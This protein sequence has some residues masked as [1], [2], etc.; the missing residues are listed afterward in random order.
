MELKI[1]ELV[2]GFENGRITRRELIGSLSLIVGSASLPSVGEAA[3]PTRRPL[4]AT[5]FNQVSFV[6]PDYA[7]TRDFYAD[8]LSLRVAK[9]D[10]KTKQCVLHLAD[11]TFMGIISKRRI[12][13]TRRRRRT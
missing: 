1:A 13:R 9:D 10:P 5:G 2:Q 6:V 7:R 4:K 11:D 12:T 8:L 3:Q